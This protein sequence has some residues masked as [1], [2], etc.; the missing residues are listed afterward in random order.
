MRAILP[1]WAPAAAGAGAVYLA[2]AVL[3]AAPASL[4]P[5]RTIPDLGDPLHLSW[6]MA[7]DAHQIVRHP[8]A[9]FEAN[10]FYPYPRSL[11]FG[12]HL[13]PEALLVAPIFWA[14]GNAV[15]SSNCAVLLALTLSGTALFLLMRDVTGSVPVA[16]LSGVAYAFNT[17]TRSEIL[18]V[19]VLNFE[20]WPLAFLCIERLAST[21]KRKYGFLLAATLLVQG[22]SGAYYLIYSVL[23]APAWLIAS[24]LAARRRPGVGELSSLVGAS[25]AAALLALPVLWPYAVQL[26]AMG[27]EKPL[28]VGVD[29]LSYFEPLPTSLLGGLQFLRP[30][31]DVP[32]F[33]GFLGAALMAVGV[34]RVLGGRLV[35]RRRIVGLL[36]LVT[37]LVGFALSLGPA[38]VVAGRT[39]GP[40]PYAL[41]YRFVPLSRGMASPVRA[42]VLVVLGG[43]VL[44]G[45]G[46]EPLLQAFGSRGRVLAAGL[47]A[48]LLPAEHW[49][50]P[51]PAA[52]VPTGSE[53]PAVYAFLAGEPAEPM[54]DLPLYPDV[55]KRL[56]AV[57]PYLSTYHW[58]PIPIGRTSFYPPAHDYLAWSLRDFPDD[59][60]IGLLSGLGIKTVVVHPF[61]WEDP[62]EREERLGALDRDPRVRLVRHFTD[63]PPDRD[64]ELQLGDERVYTIVDA[65]PTEPALC[66]PRDEVPR[67][68]WTFGGTG[69]SPG[70]RAI[71]G[72]RRTAWF[73][74]SPQKPGDRFEVTLPEPETLSA[75]SVDL[76]YPH[77]EF[78]RNLVLALKEPGGGWHRVSF[79]DGPLERGALIKALVERPREASLVLPFPAERAQGFRLMVGW[80]QADPAWPAFSVPEVHAF[81]ACSS[82]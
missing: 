79:A 26:R 11:A 19:Q 31:A 35:D 51:R 46:V 24:Y 64:K 41:L 49:S 29:V 42:A 74:A 18:R 73:T 48:F 6:V 43:S 14:T 57:Y 15:L 36:G 9:L 21:G 54:I 52:A 82:P 59:L 3:W 70:R 22:L 80:R 50:P 25:A 62:K 66:T 67:V 39:L 10:T 20:W 75:V 27:F 78:A 38:V 55:A 4:H 2:L 68:G 45:L 76:W 30:H 23:L 60:S 34:F 7:W 1:P 17:F 61:V 58:R 12:D 72:D 28:H 16:L 37:A 13:L 71:D 5:A 81:R 65:P 77:A 47:L 53:V 44:L 69:I 63:V 40:G 56:W 8:F 32:H 33:V